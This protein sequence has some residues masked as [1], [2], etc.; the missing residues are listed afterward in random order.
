[1]A[2][3][4][5]FAMDALVE[6]YGDDASL[7]ELQATEIRSYLLENGADR[8]RLS[9]ACAFAV[10]SDASDVLPRITTMRYFRR[11]HSEIPTQVVRGSA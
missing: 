2:T 8:A 5:A 11:E 4:T 3:D 7:D 10:G 1:M 6:C 9:R